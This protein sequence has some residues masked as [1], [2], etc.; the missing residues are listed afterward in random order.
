MAA[1]VGANGGGAE[2]DVV[3]V[4]GGVLSPAISRSSAAAPVDVLTPDVLDLS[5]AIR[6]AMLTSPEVQLARIQFLEA[7]LALREEESV[8]RPAESIETLQAEHT[9]KESRGA[10]FESLIDSAY[11]AQ[12]AFYHALRTQ[13]LL[14]LQKR[15]AEQAQTQLAIA[16]ARY[17]G[18]TLARLDL[19]SVELDYEEAE[20]ELQ[21]ATQRHHA[22]LRALAALTGLDPLPPLAWTE[23]DFAYSPL[24]ISLSQALAHTR[25]AHP[26]VV[27]AQDELKLADRRL[28]HARLAGLPPVRQR[29]MELAE[30]RAQIQFRQAVQRAEE[31]LR[32]VWDEVQ[33]A[34]ATLMLREKRLALA[35]QR[36]QLMQ[37]RHEAGAASLLELFAAETEVLQARLDA[38]QALW[39]YNLKK[40]QLLRLAGEGPPILIP[41][42]FEKLLSKGSTLP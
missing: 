34:E 31:D 1:I 17:R 8:A 14:E 16:R 22:A 26:N 35:L 28:E 36:L 41:A 32:R 11:K 20:A 13:E 7:E 24:G 39:D 5:S 10:L 25:K 40:A 37:T 2:E 23:G 6:T 19:Q 18:G 3:A 30:E 9:L 4:S 15:R 33:S 12:E 29:R 21:D 42:E 38:S 27:S